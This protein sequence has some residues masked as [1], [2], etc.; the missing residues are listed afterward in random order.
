MVEYYD[1]KKNSYMCPEVKR[2]NRW[3]Q[4]PTTVIAISYNQCT[5]SSCDIV[6]GLSLYTTHCF[7]TQQN[8]QK[9][10][11]V[12]YVSDVLHILSC[13]NAYIVISW[14]VRSVDYAVFKF[15]SSFD[16]KISCV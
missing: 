8:H 7:H 14:L 11:F 12:S 2:V 9:V 10:S 16:Q 6:Y 1:S 4:I 3:P 13:K 5:V 15:C